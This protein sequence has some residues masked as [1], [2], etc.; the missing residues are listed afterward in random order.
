[1]AF[2]ESTSKQKLVS[3]KKMLSLSFLVVLE[4]VTLVSVNS[5][6][7]G[8]EQIKRLETLRRTCQRYDD[9]LTYEYP[10]TVK[11]NYLIIFLCRCLM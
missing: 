9:D 2:E 1:M 5:Y 4:L 6:D 11:T 3:N 7:P 10:G 8:Q